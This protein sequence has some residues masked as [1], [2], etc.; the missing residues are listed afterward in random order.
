M[1]RAMLL[2][3]MPVTLA[4][5]F[6]M[7]PQARADATPEC[8][9]GP[10]TGSTECGSGSTAGGVNATAVGQGADASGD[11]TVAVGQIAVASGGNSVAVGSGAQSLGLESVALGFGAQTTAPNT[12]AIG[13]ASQATQANSIAIGDVAQTTAANSVAL[14]ANSLA[15]QESTVSVGSASQQRRIVNAAPGVDPNDVVVMSQL[16]GIGGGGDSLVQQDAV[17]RTITVG[18]GTD[19]ALVDMT[20][21][22][23]VRRL[24]GLLDG[25][26]A[27][28]A[29][30]FGQLTTVADLLDA[31]GQGT[32]A[33]LGGGASF[34]P[35]GLTAPG[36][37]VQGGTFDNVGDALGAIDTQVTNNSNAIVDINNIIGSGSIGLVQQASAGA[38]L[39]VGTATDGAQVNF[40]GTAGNRRLTGVA[41]GAVDA[42]SADAVNGSQLF[43]TAQ[44]A[45]AIFGGGATVNAGGVL[46]PPSYV[47]QG[48]SFSNVGDALGAIDTQVTDNAGRIDQI[49]V[50]LAALPPTAFVSDDSRGSGAPVAVGSEAAAGG[51][52]A[53]AAATRALAL[54]NNSLATGVGSMAVG[55][56]SA[57]R[58]EGAIAMG[59]GAQ[60]NGAFSISIGTGNIVEG[61]GS[62]AFGDPNIV[63]GSGSYA[64]GNDNTIDADNAFVLGSNVTVGAGLNGA[65]VLGHNS[66]VAAAVGTTGVTINGVSY[67]FAGTAPASTVSIGAPGAER[68]LTNLAA[69]R[70]SASSTDAVNGSQLFATNQA[71]EQLQTGVGDLNDR[72]VLYDDASKASVT[73]GGASGTRLANVANGAVGAGSTDAVNG[74]QLHATAQG[75]A[76]ALGGGAGVD[77]SGAVIAPSYAVQGGTFNNVG[78]ALGA[79]DTQVTNN[80]SN[81]ASLSNDVTNITNNIGNGTIGLVQQ[82]GAGAD[83]TVGAGT[84]GAQV[85]FAGTAGNR[86]LTGVAAGAVNDAS[87]DAVNGAQL[88]ETNIRIEDVQNLVTGAALGGFRTDN[89]SRLAA[90]QTPG[91][92]ASA[93]GNG[94]VAS[95]A[96]ATAVGNS[97]IATA[98]NS[99]ALG[100]GSRSTGT[101]SVALGAGSTDEG[102]ANVVSVGSAGG[103]RRITNVSN[104]TRFTDAV[105]L[106]QLNAGM[107]QALVSANAYTDARINALQFDLK[108]ARRDAEGA[109]AAAMALAGIPQSYQPGMGMVG[110]GVGTWQGESAIA[111]GVSKAS[112]DGTFVVKVGGAYNTRSEG[113]ASAGFGIAF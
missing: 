34:G 57:A 8:N 49:V 92:D 32:A 45:A 84:D 41:P 107:N 78:D 112:E 99:T 1:F 5:S 37:A 87:T 95:G 70:L 30:T 105:N 55:Q 7:A 80:T 18:A 16:S 83:L 39:T 20:G 64:F 42:G 43:G 65:V 6:G 25:T 56:A 29:A 98:A 14:G 88:N 106:G 100:S 44:S 38:D 104:G 46:T 86:R 52:G 53:V 90:P 60:A 61:A 33:A 108:K 76:S 12:I 109:T 91:T 63:N 35:A 96:R 72:A 4:V 62:G 77:A 85:S 73:L 22:D 24:T 66:S 15:D 93:G 17:S 10:D 101:N 74:S 113:G 23:G 47:V 103:E 97:A 58:G 28:D 82:A 71:I 75:T 81:I 69:G 89:T 59:D 110:M 26:A 27:D 11:G 40:T 94:A 111:M 31:T 19:G 9:D 79:I 13:R 102:L 54:G 2:A 36:Y 68:T 3:A 67:G 51:R 50:E 21:T 48:G